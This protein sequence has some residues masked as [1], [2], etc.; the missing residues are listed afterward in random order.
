MIA[1]LQ[2][3]APLL[4]AFVLTVSLSLTACSPDPTVDVI[5]PGLGPILAAQA[6]NAEV[7]AV[8]TPE[9]LAIAN[10][11]PE[12]ITA[13]LPEDF[14]AALASA[15]AANGEALSLTNACVGCHA[16]DPNQ[17]M[18]GPTWFDIA[19]TAANRV[20]GESPALYLYHSI[21]LPNSY[22]VEGYPQN[23]MPQNYQDLLTQE[24]L[25]DIVAYLLTQHE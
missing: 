21:M 11:S 19:D 7:E 14:A 25:A 10:L 22:V 6:A 9:P 12:E 5:S 4:M 15:D 1:L 23:I 13:G 17:Q 8:P 20:P 16:L 24:D 2:K 3:R 18:T